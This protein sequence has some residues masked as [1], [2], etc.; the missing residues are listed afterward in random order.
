MATEVKD[1]TIFD[2]KEFEV[3]KVEDV[4]SL[5]YK[6][7]KV[8]VANAPFE[9]DDLKKL[10]DYKKQ[11]IKEATSIAVDKA[12][13]V[14]KKDSNIDRVIAKVPFT[15]SSKGSVEISID[16][17]KTFRVPGEENKTVT[18]PKVT[19]IVTEPYNKLSKNYMLK[20]EESISVALSKNK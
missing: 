2:S 14:L 5:T 11:Y 12:I 17:E 13:Q 18:K 1:K 9:L 16:R 10:E 6:D 19:T 4:A 20:I 3:N 7:D 15:T 8:F